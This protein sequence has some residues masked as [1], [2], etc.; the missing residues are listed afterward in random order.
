VTN[1]TYGDPRVRFRIPVGVAYGSDVNK[2]RAAF[3][4]RWQRK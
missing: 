1:W 2:V 4:R 3:D